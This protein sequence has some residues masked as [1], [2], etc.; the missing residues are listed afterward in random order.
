MFDSAM[1]YGNYLACTVEPTDHMLQHLKDNAATI[2][3]TGTEFD[4]YTT[5][6]KVC[7]GYDVDTKRELFGYPLTWKY[8]AMPEN[9][10]EYRLLER[11]TL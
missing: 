9:S 7:I 10:P 8:P 1:E 5:V 4:I 6:E 2:L 3:P 11:V